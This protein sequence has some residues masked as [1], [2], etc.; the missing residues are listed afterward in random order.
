LMEA[1]LSDPEKFVARLLDNRLGV[2]S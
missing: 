1:L 2:E